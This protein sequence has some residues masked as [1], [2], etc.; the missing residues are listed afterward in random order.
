VGTVIK[1]VTGMPSMPVTEGLV[2]ALTSWAFYAMNG[3]D[4]PI[5]SF[6]AFLRTARHLRGA[7]A[8][9]ETHSR[10]FT[11]FGITAEFPAA[12]T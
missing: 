9:I 5:S 11:D 8:R 10:R 4:C 3:I 2:K 1:A 6:S 7:T 12:M